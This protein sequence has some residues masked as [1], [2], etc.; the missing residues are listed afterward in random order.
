MQRPHLPDL[1][2]GARAQAGWIRITAVIGVSR[3]EAS[4]TASGEKVLFILVGKVLSQPPR[5]QP[6]TEAS[7][8]SQSRGEN[9]GAL[10]PSPS[11]FCSVPSAPTCPPTAREENPG[12]LAPSLLLYQTRDWGRTATAQTFRTSVHYS[13]GSGLRSPSFSLDAEAWLPQMSP[14]LEGPSVV[15]SRMSQVT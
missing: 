3:K 12:V 4:G 5:L 14:V 9:P 10:A 8:P 7:L 6:Q 15:P 11:P 13:P 1:S 2:T